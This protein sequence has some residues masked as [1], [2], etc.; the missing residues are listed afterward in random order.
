VGLLI[1]P[2]KPW[3]EVAKDLETYKHT[4]REVNAAESPP[5]VMAG[6]VFCDP[7]PDKAMEGARKY[8][9]AY[10]QTILRHY[11]LLDDYLSKLRGYESYKQV[12]KDAGPEMV[13]K[14]TEFF[15]RLQVWGTPEQCYERIVEFKQRTGAEAFTGVFSYG[16]MPFDLAERNMR[17]FAREVMPELKKLV[18]VEQQAIARS[19]AGAEAT[20]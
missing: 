10:Y 19:A 5:P 4:Y 11:E 17:M 1:I 8:I 3:D 16:A 18:P 13:D 7:D 12:G 15:L 14:M 2:Q 9:G 6:W 20:A